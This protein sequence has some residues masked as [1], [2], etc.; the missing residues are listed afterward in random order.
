MKSVFYFF[1]LGLCWGPFKKSFGQDTLATLL[2]QK[3]TA[4]YIDY[5]MN[6]RMADRELYPQDSLHLWLTRSVQLAGQMRDTTKW[7]FA[8]Y[9]LANFYYDISDPER[10]QKM[11]AL[12]KEIEGYPE[13]LGAKKVL[14]HVYSNYGNQ[15]AL[16]YDSALF[17]TQKSIDL[18]P[19]VKDTLLL[20]LNYKNLSMFYKRQGK[21]S[22]CITAGYEAVRIS[23]FLPLY[24]LNGQNYFHLAD[25]LISNERLQEARSQI[26]KM[27]DWLDRIDPITEHQRYLSLAKDIS[28]LYE[29]IDDPENA[30]HFQKK[31]TEVLESGYRQKWEMEIRS[32]EV[33]TKTREKENKILALELKSKNEKFRNRQLWWG[34]GGLIFLTAFLFLFYRYRQKYLSR[35][36]DRLKELDAF[37]TRLYTNITHEFRT[38]LTV[39]LGM[40]KLIADNPSE[41]LHQGA[42][43]IR[44][45]G[46]QLLD[47]VNQMLD[48]AKLESGTL[49]LHRRRGDLVLFLKYLTQAFQSFAAAKKI[50]LRFD[51]EP[52][53]L[54]MDFDP[55]K[56]TKVFSNLISNAL[57]F[58]PEDGH[59]DIRITGGE[60]QAE[61][62]IADTGTGIPAAYLPYI[63]DRF[64][65]GQHGSD[66]QAEGTGIGLTLAK[67]LIHLMGGTI[68]VKSSP[69]RGTE[70]TVLLPVQLETADRW[71]PVDS[72]NAGA[73]LAL[74]TL[75][76]PVE[77]DLPVALIIED[78]KDVVQ[79]LSACLKNQYNLEIA[80]DGKRGIEK[81]LELVPDIVIS[82]VMMPEKDGF[83]VCSTLKQDLR[84]SHIPI[85][86]LTARADK[87]SRMD[88]LEQGAD[89]YLEKPFDQEELEVRLRKLIELRKRLREKY[90]AAD[91]DQVMPGKETD[92]ELLFLKQLE[93]VVLANL[94]N[95]DFKVEPDLCRAMTMSR[96][97]LY[98]KIKAIKDQSPSE[99]L[100]TVRM[101]RA[102]QLLQRTGISVSE[103]ARQVGFKEHS[104]FTQVYHTTFGE[105][106]SD[107]RKV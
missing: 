89:V 68:T 97:Q 55:D 51:S 56:L 28:Y 75:E 91:L 10:P 47:L 20:M 71:N 61:V 48:L 3:D 2:A 67:E 74:P 27:C 14:A 70:F 65:Q 35:E 46:R 7:L 66:R 36:A 34:V 31:Y 95:D 41:W 77:E 78:N 5:V 82:D 43:A 92:P 29:R 93:Q 9:N 62:R 87:T 105:T 39:I 59:I 21:L 60:N 11:R 1:F 23:Q 86:L 4:G 80:F 17:Y 83:E 100:R 37:K 26:G 85:V 79:Y 16:P 106:P 84:T 33:L 88:G 50:H 104:H 90:Q 103:V 96:P 30:L 24:L 18:H 8:K 81:A 102:R 22:D 107:M 15:V 44:R 73:D 98:R 57:K 101:Q 94:D 76:N 99:F 45:N 54:E 32:L 58:T 63:F 52:A 53:T 19:V 72:E 6:V 40:T 12:M 64:Y 25:C 42:D 13:S 69:G 49:S 38:P